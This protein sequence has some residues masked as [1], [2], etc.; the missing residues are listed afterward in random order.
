MP[1]TGNE[2]TDR[3]TVLVAAGT[4]GVG[5]TFADWGAV[6]FTTGLRNHPT[7]VES[8]TT[9]D[10]TPNAR[11]YEGPINVHLAATAELYANEWLSFVPVLQIPILTSPV[12]YGPMIGLGVR[13]TFDT[14]EQPKAQM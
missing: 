4:F 2:H 14:V 11:V 8:F 13:A 3:D 10:S 9:T 7:N 5:W 12:R 6:Q 1:V